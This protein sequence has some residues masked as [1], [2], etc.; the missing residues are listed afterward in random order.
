MIINNWNKLEQRLSVYCGCI[1]HFP[2]INHHFQGLFHEFPM[3]FPMAF[4]MIFPGKLLN[5]AAIHPFRGDGWLGGDFPPGNAGAVLFFTKK[6]G[7]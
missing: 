2:A 6:N 5:Q 7:G 3:A 4:P 1:S